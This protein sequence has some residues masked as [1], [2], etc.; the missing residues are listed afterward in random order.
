MPDREVGLINNNG[1][2]KVVRK[3]PRSKRR[4]K[5]NWI[6]G[7]TITTPLGPEYCGQKYAGEINVQY[8]D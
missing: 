3:P 7:Y 5:R 8:F 1:W 2:G 6:T 4:G